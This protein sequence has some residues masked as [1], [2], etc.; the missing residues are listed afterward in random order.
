MTRMGIDAKE[1]LVAADGPRVSPSSGDLVGSI[2]S[3]L[4]SP[5]TSTRNHY[6]RLLSALRMM[7]ISGE[8]LLI[9]G[10]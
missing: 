4:A 7:L 5:S 3:S 6:R 9:S 1:L 8:L 2:R 10:V